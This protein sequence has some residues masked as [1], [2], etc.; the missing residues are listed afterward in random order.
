MPMPME[1]Q[2]ASDAFERYLQD[3]RETSGL[4]TRHQVYTMTQGVFQAFRRRLSFEEALRFAD[5]LPP[6]LRAIFVADWDVNEPRRP[7]ED[8][9]AMTEDVKSLRRD[10]NFSPDSA[11]KNVAAALRKNIDADA[12]DRVLS[13]LPA[14]AQEFWKP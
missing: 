10:H 6:L 3:A 4:T 14:E 5:V 12:L 8:R 1:Y 2:H 7:F 13:T 11:I 9:R